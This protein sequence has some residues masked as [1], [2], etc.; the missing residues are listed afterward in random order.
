M[1]GDRLLWGVKQSF[2]SYV[3]MTGGSI[4]AGEGAERDADGGFVF[5]GAGLTLD[6][7]G[8]PQG[9]GRF[10]G[11]I[12]F[13]AHGGMLSVHL[14]DPIVAFGP[15]GATLSVE[16]RGAGGRRAEIARLD[17][18]AMSRSGDEYVLPATV[19][20]EGMQVL[21]DHYPPGTPI[22]PVRLRLSAAG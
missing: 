4:E 20:P 12:R 11:A 3:Q 17:A 8:R 15:E 19:T 22:D 13:E 21:G 16:D 9:E 1:A 10:S 7:D 2:R 14:A 6:A 5:A 18:G